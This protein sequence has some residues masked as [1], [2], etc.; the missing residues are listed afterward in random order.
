MTEPDPPATDV[1]AAADEPASKKQKT[2]GCEEE[3]GTVAPSRE[4]ADER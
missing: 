1:D 3:K 4:E 2:D